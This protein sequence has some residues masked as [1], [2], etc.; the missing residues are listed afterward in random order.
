MRSAVKGATLIIVI[1][2]IMLFGILG[3]TLAVMQSGSLES[4]LRTVQSEQALYLA[5]AG[6][7]WGIYD[8][9]TNGVFSSAD[10]VCN[11]TNDWKTHNLTPGQYQ[12]CTRPPQ[13][14]ET[15]TMVV[16]SIGYVP[17]AAA[18]NAKRKVKIAASS[19]SFDKTVMAR[20]LFNWSSC[21]KDERGDS[22]VTGDMLCLYYEGSNSL[23]GGGNGIYNEYGI[24][25]SNSSDNTYLLPKTNRQR[26]AARYVGESL[27][28][29]LDMGFYENDTN[30]TIL[31]PSNTSKIVNV[32]NAGGYANIT[33]AT[34]NFFGP[35]ANWPSLTGHALRDISRGTWK[36]G[37]WKDILY[38]V[39][40]TAA[41][42]NGTVDWEVGERVTRVPRIRTAPTFNAGQHR[43]NFT[44]NGTLS[45][46]TGQVIRNYSKGTWNY[47][48]WGVISS[49]TS[50]N[51]I[52]NVT[53]Q[54]D[55]SVSSG[56]WQLNDLIGFVRR[57][58]HVDTNNGGL[59]DNKQ[60]LYVESDVLFDVR[61]DEMDT[62]RTGI[63]AE[64]D[65]VIRGT[66][67]LLLEK[68]PLLYPNIATKYGNIY[69]PD[70][71]AGNNRNQRL[72]NRRFDDILFS[73]FGNI[74]FNYVD[75][76]AMY[77]S[78][79]T[80]SGVFRITYDTDLTKIGGY[81]FGVSSYEWKEE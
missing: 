55:T 31:M 32:T 35:S 59:L 27:F 4:S 49:R 62:D 17:N 41:V 45:W 60:L 22:Y 66:D 78:N 26:A 33:V 9:I 28:P 71:P 51:N 74:Q 52:T 3:W 38:I 20:N 61:D 65:A 73:E 8:Y 37:T 77:A 40:S 79:I 7:R 58:S 63:V 69:S 76:M 53:V 57:L 10:S 68:R 5:E 11:V 64:G 13:T 14:G 29:E 1:F 23:N 47:T 24:D 75:C 2:V 70:L 80:L 34:A 54:M 46:P 48:D 43:Y 44:I 18:Y 67:M 50:A 81:G 36:N 42:L 72:D 15:G 6:G 21:T 56:T 16:E 25:Y 12:V 30:A 39:N 19:G